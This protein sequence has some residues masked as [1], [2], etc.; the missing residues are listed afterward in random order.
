M[1]PNIFMFKG[2]RSKVTEQ[3][4]FSMATNTANIVR[5]LIR[6]QHILWNVRLLELHTLTVN[7]TAWLFNGT[8]SLLNL[9]RLDPQVYLESGPATK[10]GESA[11]TKQRTGRAEAAEEND[12]RQTVWKNYPW[13][14]TLTSWSL[15]G[16]WRSVWRKYRLLK[17]Q[18]GVKCRWL[19][20]LS[21]FYF[22]VSK[23]SQKKHLT[24]SLLFYCYLVKQWQKNYEVIPQMFEQLLRITQKWMFVLACN[25]NT[26]CFS[27]SPK[28]QFIKQTRICLFKSHFYLLKVHINASPLGH[29]L[30]WP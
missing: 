15:G 27:V 13:G 8:R 22:F 23:A 9:Y 5:L 17:L 12:H 20:L 4:E 14:K 25:S 24:H 1:A 19:R 6:Y 21:Y 30:G 2:F 29:S 18:H 7:A 11:E 10:H 28:F 3:Q 16:L 26:R